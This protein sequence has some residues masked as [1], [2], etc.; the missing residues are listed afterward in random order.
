[1]TIQDFCF[2]WRGKQQAFL[3]E[4]DVNLLEPIALYNQN[5]GRALLLLHGFSS[6]PAVFRAI[7]PQLPAYDAIV[8]PV[9]P[10]HAE[11]ITAFAKVTSNDWIV[12][13]EQAC[14]MLLARYHLV[15]V[16]GLSLGGLLACHLSSKYTLN[17]LYLL[18]PALDLQL[19]LNL[20]LFAAQCLKSLGVRLL[21]NRAGNLQSNQ[22]SELTYRQLPLHAIIEILSLVKH[23]QFKQPNCPTDVLLGRF[24]KVVDSKKIAARFK[25]NSVATI[26]WL[27]HSAHI[28]PLDGDIQTIIATMYSRQD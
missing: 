6:S 25:A 21:R 22:F 3:S 18:A 20:T 27:E 4:K 28:L 14:E 2:A 15:D 5:H 19:P 13:A 12:T 10:G 1:M 8:C 16:M 17:H 23:F 11:S 7:L 24:D 9:L 26:H